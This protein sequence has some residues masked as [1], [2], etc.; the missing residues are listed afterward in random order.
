M[1]EDFC[2][3]RGYVV[4][5]ADTFRVYDP[6]HDRQVQM[7]FV[8]APQKLDMAFFYRAYEMLEPH[9]TH[10]IFVYAVATIQIKKLKLY[11][12]VLKIEFFGIHE[13][14]RLLGGNRLIPPHRQLTATEADAV[15]LRF[16]SDHLPSLL[17]SD[18]L[19][20]LYDFDLDAIIQIDRAMGVYYR[21]VVPDE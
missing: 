17:Q 8:Q 9:V 12:D 5:A 1:F 3:L 19:S 4:V 13:L 6:H 15:R 16:G 14:R 10:M 18:P 7:F 11:K 21:R 2:R 20:R